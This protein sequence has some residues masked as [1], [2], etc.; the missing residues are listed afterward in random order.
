[1][2]VQQWRVNFRWLTPR[3]YT[4]VSAGERDVA[5]SGPVCRRCRKARSAS[6]LIQ[7]LGIAFRIGIGCR[8]VGG[9]ATPQAGFT[10]RFTALLL[11]PVFLDS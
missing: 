8:L 3:P 10:T 4:R 9:R 6:A 7:Q 1:M 2:R 5:T 11:R